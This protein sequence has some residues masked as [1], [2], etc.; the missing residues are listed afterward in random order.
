MRGGGARLCE[1][2][3]RQVLVW[4]A[5]GPRAAGL[6]CPSERFWKPAHAC[7]CAAVCRGNSGGLGCRGTGRLRRG[8][9]QAMQRP[10]GR[11]W[12]RA[13]A[14]ACAA[15]YRRN[16]VSS[17]C[18]TGVFLCWCGSQCCRGCGCAGALACMQQQRS[19]LGQR[20]LWRRCRGAAGCVVQRLP[21]RLRRRQAGWRRRCASK[22]ALAWREAA[23]LDGLPWQEKRTS[24]RHLW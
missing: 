21:G 15:A 2:Q 17:C 14:R 10:A 18:R 6:R 7:A 19:G 4:G 1:A 8:G 20:G 22:P 11:L 5:C 23:A 3:R 9:T 12:Q 16:I 24:E 13:S